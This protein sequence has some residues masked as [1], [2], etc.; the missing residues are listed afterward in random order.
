[1]TMN[2][3]FPILEAL[4]FIPFNKQAIVVSKKIDPTN[5]IKP[6]PFLTYAVATSVIFTGVL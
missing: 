4:F 1:M 5:D 3:L 2:I 6:S